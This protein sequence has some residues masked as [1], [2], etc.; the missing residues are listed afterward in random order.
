M[1]KTRK[2]INYICFLGL[3]VYWTFWCRSW[4]WTD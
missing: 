2:L 4:G 1:S 3:K